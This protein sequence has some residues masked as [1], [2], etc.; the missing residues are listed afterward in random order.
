MALKAGSLDDLSALALTRLSGRLDAAIT[1]S[2]AGGRQDARVR[3]TGEGVRAASLALSRLDADL[4]GTDLWASPRV[5]GRLN[6]DRLV[7]GSE[8]IEAIRL[9][10]KPAS[11]GS[12]L[13]LQARAGASPSTAPPGWFRPITRASTSR[14]SPPSAGPT[15]WRSPA[16]PGSP[17][18]TTAA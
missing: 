7:A 10:A 6:A 1:L 9:D 4:A 17:S 3:A 2:R 8:T 18:A 13:L 16:R 12:D 14:A 15:G 11:D 5:S